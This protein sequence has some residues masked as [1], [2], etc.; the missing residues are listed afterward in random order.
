MLQE[1]PEGRMLLANTTDRFH[2]THSH[3][4]QL[5]RIL[6]DQR[7]YYLLGYRPTE[8]TFNRHFH[9]IKAKVKR[10]GMTL[11]TRYG[12]FGVSE[13]EANRGRL[14]AQ[15]PMTLAL[16][17]P[18]AEQNLEVGVNSFFTSGNPEGSIV[19][20]FLYLNPAN[21]SFVRNNGRYETA[22]EIH[23]ALFGDNGS[24]ANKEIGR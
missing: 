1:N 7:G 14:K 22:L 18:F 4:L 12:F 6:E 3:G 13:E 5:D 9:Q 20:S 2:V 10:S 24:M 16:I 21:L 17:S 11:R 15:D 23:G 8:E 19:R